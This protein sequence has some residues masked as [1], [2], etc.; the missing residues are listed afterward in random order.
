MK[1]LTTSLPTTPMRVRC[2]FKKT[3]VGQSWKRGV[4]WFDPNDST[5]RTKKWKN[6]TKKIL[7]W[8]PV[9]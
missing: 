7:A 2:S 5:F 3:Q 6:A 8:E 4:Y 9:D 1:Q